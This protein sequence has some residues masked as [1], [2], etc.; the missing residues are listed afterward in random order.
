MMLVPMTWQVAV[1]NS[2]TD[3]HCIGALSNQH[4]VPRHQWL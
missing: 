2:S 1:Q 3:V 4:A